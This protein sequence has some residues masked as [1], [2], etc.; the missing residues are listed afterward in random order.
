[1]GGNGELTGQICLSSLTE[2]KIDVINFQNLL[3]IKCPRLKRFAALKIDDYRQNSTVFESF[4]QNNPEIEELEL[5]SCT[6]IFFLDRRPVIDVNDV[7]KFFTNF[8]KLRIFKLPR[9]KFVNTLEIAR[10]IGENFGKLEHFEMA[11]R[12]IE[13]DEVTN[14]FKQKLPHYRTEVSYIGILSSCQVIT[15][16]K[17]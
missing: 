2:I 4:A 15:V 10:F 8:P 1:L 14:Y 13:E 9:A 11:L 7:A 12:E 6:H 5:F 17:L 16:K 3:L